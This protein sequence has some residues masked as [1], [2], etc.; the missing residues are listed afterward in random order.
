MS[1]NV[2]MRP[3]HFE[4][5]DVSAPETASVMPRKP[6]RMPSIT[7]PR[8]GGRARLRR[9][10]LLLMESVYGGRAGAGMGRLVFPA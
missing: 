2:T 9:V 7:P 10:L 4:R 6:L 5:F 8:L 1:S 3:T